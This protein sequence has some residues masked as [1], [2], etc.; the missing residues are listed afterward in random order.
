MTG[1]GMVGVGVFEGVGGRGEIVGVIVRVG[2]GVRVGIGV[3]VKRGVR[4]TMGASVAVACWAICS[5]W[6]PAT[7]AIR[8][9]TKVIIRNRIR[10]LPKTKTTKHPSD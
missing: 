10:H 2:V 1:G 7:A 6:Q 9:R 5:P 8:I 3:A 4:L